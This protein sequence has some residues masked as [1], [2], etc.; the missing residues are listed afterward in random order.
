MLVVVATCDVTGAVVCGV[1][2]DVTGVDESGGGAVSVTMTAVAVVGALTLVVS[3]VS[4]ELPTESWGVLWCKGC[5]QKELWRGVSDLVI[6]SWR[7]GML[8]SMCRVLHEEHWEP[9]NFMHPQ[10]QKENV[11]LGLLTGSRPSR[12]M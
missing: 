2:N 8:K 5:R 11:G 7:A 3:D 4:V 1:A 6:L 9:L 12:V 10:R